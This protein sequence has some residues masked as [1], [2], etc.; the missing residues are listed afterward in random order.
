VSLLGSDA[1]LSWSHGGGGLTIQM[2][3][4][5]PCEHAVAFKVQLKP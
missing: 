4:E 1:P 3:A 5:A 2:P